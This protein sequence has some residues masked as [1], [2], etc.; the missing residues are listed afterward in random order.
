MY[1]LLNIVFRKIV[2][3]AYW[4]LTACQYNRQEHTFGAKGAFNKYRLLL[5]LSRTIGPQEQTVPA[6]LV[7]MDKWYTKVVSSIQ[8]W[9]G[10]LYSIF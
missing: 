7:P 1:L 5:I 9:F 2:V 6:H 3:M 4:K 8:K 10:K